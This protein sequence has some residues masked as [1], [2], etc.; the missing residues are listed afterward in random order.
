MTI[1]EPH[2]PA[3]RGAPQS[4]QALS[5]V[6]EAAKQPVTGDGREVGAAP[7]RSRRRA[8]TA[9]VAALVV[10]L[11]LAAAAYALLPADVKAGIRDGLRDTPVTAPN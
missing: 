10:S 4:Q 8:A 9:M 6:R 11:A 3:A 2:R 5:D 7:L 1:D